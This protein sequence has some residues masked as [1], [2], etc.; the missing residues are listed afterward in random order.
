MCL[1]VVAGA[2]QFQGMVLWVVSQRTGVRSH[3]TTHPPPA[4]PAS[5]LGGARWGG[6]VG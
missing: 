1:E 6:D 4:Q 2:K 5:L 3:C